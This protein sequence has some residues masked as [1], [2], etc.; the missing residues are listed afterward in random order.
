MSYNI[1]GKVFTEHA[2]MDEIVFNSKIILEKIVIKN[3]ELANNC[4]E[5]WFIDEV[6]VFMMIMNNTITS[7]VFPFTRDMLIRY[8]C[9]EK[10]IRTYLA[11]REDI[12]YDEREPLV[13]FC[14][15]IFLDEYIEK[16]S[17]YRMLMGLPEYGTDE[18]NVYIDDS[19]LPV[20]YTR[21]IDYSKPIHEFD[22]DVLA[23]LNSCGG[24][25]R[26][27]SEHK[28]SKYAYLRFLGD[29]SIDLYTA[30]KASK[31][32]ILYMP[33]VE[34]LV[35]DRFRELYT[36]NRDMFLKRTYSDAYAFD[37]EY[38]EQICILLILCQTFNDMIVDTP[39]WYIRRDIFDIRSV[40]YFLESFGVAFYDIIPLKYQIRIVKN[41]NKLIKYKSS[42]KN[43]ADILEIFALPNTSIY[44][45]YL[46][47]KRKLDGHG[48]YATGDNE[49]DKYELQFVQS[50][51]NE[52]YDDY[53]KDEIYRHQYDEITYQDK[54][55]DGED[56]HEWIKQMH[57]NRDFTIEGTKYMSLEYKIDMQE[58]LFQ[59]EY[60]IGL[61]LDSNIENDITIGIP[62][63]QPG[64]EFKVS[65]L[66]LF[67]YLMSLGYDELDTKIIRPGDGI[68][69]IYTNYYDV[70]GGYPDSKLYTSDYNGYRAAQ[71]VG[72]EYLN[73]DG[74]YADNSGDPMDYKLSRR[75]PKPE[76]TKYD[77]YDGGYSYTHEEEYSEKYTL[78]GGGIDGG[79]YLL[80]DGGK[81][82]EWTE[83]KSV[84]DF[85]DWMKKYYPEAFINHEDRVYGFNTAVDMDQLRETLLRRHPSHYFD[86]DDPERDFD[87]TNFKTGYTLEELGI[88]KY[89]VPTNISTFQE[90][91]DVYYT[92]RECYTNLKEKIV[93]HCDDRVESKVLNYAFEE[94][95]TK[96]FDYVGYQT[97]D[98]V[99]AKYL[100]EILKDRDFVLYTIYT[101]TMSENNMDVRKSN[102][103]DIMN[104][105]INTLEYYLS[106][107]GLEYIF[108]FTPVASFISL[109]RYI[110]LMINFFK[111]Y[112]VYFLD[113]YITYVVND[114]LENDMSGKDTIGEL[115][116]QYW[117]KDKLFGRDASLLTNMII[118]DEMYNEQLLEVLDV[119]G[120]EDPDPYNDYDYDGKYANTEEPYKDA[121]GGYADSKSAIPYTMVNGGSAGGINKYNLWDLNGASAREQLE[122]VD[123]DG[124]KALEGEDYIIDYWQDAFLYTIDGGSAGTNEFI[125]RDIHTTVFDRQI[126]ADIRIANLI[127]N[128]IE[129]RPDGLY[130]KKSWM[131]YAD[132]Y[133]FKDFVDETF[134]EFEKAY[135][136]LK[137][138]ESAYRDDA[139]LT[140]RIKQVINA[141]MAGLR[142]VVSYD[143]DSAES[144]INNYTDQKVAELYDAFGNYGSISWS[145]I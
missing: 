110:L 98:G 7:N 118:T 123:A 23:V 130:L 92:N 19:Y 34:S 32:D 12:P 59:M 36:L 42:N 22:K 99:D 49:E 70:N 67:L 134:V 129:E 132:Y 81:N 13:N 43:F 24:V 137:D 3:D 38:Y 126:S 112:K 108:G 77:D 41:L 95:F 117:K 4:D 88:D 68:D 51:I 63:L 142:K 96:Q 106:G 94:L 89:I 52:S 11:N 101:K 6:E 104:D 78:N 105:I 83:I 143:V 62:S 31:Y 14:A 37:S 75:N 87:A 65:N 44:K 103:R 33:S 66:F 71:M 16:N 27:V 135:E 120:I 90:L 21:A 57:L 76:F 121:D 128:A 26:L 85:Y 86:D 100:E 91:L 145:T 60:F 30:R 29:Y 45:Y 58:Y 8:G 5:D 20:G 122:Y 53:I 136:T 82:A 107:D 141:K 72:V 138:Y 102:M 115:K 28:G 84:E 125:T 114:K 144:N 39:E 73:T 2:L 25:D 55:W 119:Y 113:P 9:T 131:D 116:L 35:E 18:Y 109:V 139:V 40:Q 50:K 111:S 54:Y 93:E 124:G 97:S 10:E 74:K 15:P 79:G 17:Y 140:D 47:K 46:F 133:G 69:Y 127:G 61:L 56:D 64:V 48:N 1:N 80:G